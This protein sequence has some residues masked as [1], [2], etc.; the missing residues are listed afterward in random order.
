L[1]TIH[2]QKLFIFSIFLAEIFV[3]RNPYNYTIKRIST[4]NFLKVNKFGKKTCKK[5][6][7]LQDLRILKKF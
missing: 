1:S 2:F 5:L 7:I 3:L 4:K 6:A